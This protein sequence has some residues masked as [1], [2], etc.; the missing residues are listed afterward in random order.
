MQRQVTWCFDRQE[1]VQNWVPLLEERFAFKPDLVRHAIPNLRIQLDDAISFDAHMS[2]DHVLV[3]HPV[4]TPRDRI[5]GHRIERMIRGIDFSSPGNMGSTAM[6]QQLLIGLVDGDARITKRT[7]SE[8]R[9]QEN[10]S[11][12]ATRD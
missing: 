6:D 4:G 7:D 5:R 3:E 9:S 8:F 12:G 2:D 11:M 1:P 10:D